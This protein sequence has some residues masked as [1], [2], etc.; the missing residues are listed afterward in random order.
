MTHHPLPIVLLMI[1]ACALLTA[2]AEEGADGQP[3]LGDP[4]SAILRPLHAVRSD[5]L[6]ALVAIT[7]DER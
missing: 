3:G 4:R 5:D 2:P 7:P 1:T 6:G